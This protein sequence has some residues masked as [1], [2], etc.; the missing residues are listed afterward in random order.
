MKRFKK[1]LV[2]IALIFLFILLSA[3]LL[4]RIQNPLSGFHSSFSSHFEAFFNSLSY[5][6]KSGFGSVREILGLGEENEKLREEN[7]RLK[8]ELED[9]K[10]YRHENIELRELLEFKNKYSP[11][12]VPAEVIGRDISN[13]FYRFEINK[14]SRHGITKNMIVVSPAG[15]IGQ[16]TAVSDRTSLVR[17][18]LNERSMIPVYVVES[19]AFA[20]LYGE[21]GND[22]SLRYIYNASLLQ[23]GQLVV[24]SGL[25]NIFPGGI[26]IGKTVRSKRNKS[27]FSIVPFA[28]IEAVRRVIVFERKNET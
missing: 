3:F 5:V 24:T 21:G 14:G 20:M 4:S 27:D 28:N 23:E 10:I 18:I 1:N 25:G 8:S 12:G 19:G 2:L 22:A 11:D 6:C 16:V 26:V 13:W 15:L 17:T 9:L 7:Q